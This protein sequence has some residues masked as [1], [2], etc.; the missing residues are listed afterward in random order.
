MDCVYLRTV[1]EVPE[2]LILSQDNMSVSE[3]INKVIK[4]AQIRELNYYKNNASDN[5]ILC[6]FNAINKFA[7][8]FRKGMPLKMHTHDDNS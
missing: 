3:I 2:C 1:D 7:M 5:I 6:K 8:R 4:L